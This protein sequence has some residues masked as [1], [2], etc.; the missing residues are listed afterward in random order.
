MEAIPLF[1]PYTMSDAQILKV[2]TAHETDFKKILSVIQNNQNKYA[3]KHIVICGPTGI[4]KSFLLRRLQIHFKPYKTIVFFLFPEIPSHLYCADDFLNDIQQFLLSKNDRMDI[5]QPTNNS[6]EENIH[7]LEHLIKMSAYKHVI[8]GIENLHMMI[9]DQGIFSSPVQQAKFQDLLQ[10]KSW[11]TL[12]TTYTDKY[13]HELD[14]F[15]EPFYRYELSEWSDQDHDQYLQKICAMHKSAGAGPNKIKQNVLRSFSG[16]LPRNSVILADILRHNNILSTI[17]ALETTI[18]WLTPYFQNQFFSL[19]PECRLLINALICSKEPCTLSELAKCVHSNE[20]DISKNIC[21]LSDHGFLNVISQDNHDAYSVKDRLFVHYYRVRHGSPLQCKRG[22]LSVVSEFL[23][24]FYD[25]Q[26]LKNMAKESFTQGHV[27]I[28]RDILHIILSHAG[29]SI[30][31]LPWKNDL[32]LLFQAFDLCFSKEFQ[33]P[34]SEKKAAIIHQQM[35]NLLKACQFY[36]NELNIKRFAYQITSHLFINEK[37][38][39]FLFQQ[40][41][42]NQLSFNQW[43]DLDLFFISQQTKLRNAY[44]EFLFPLIEMIQHDEIIPEIILESRIN[45]LKQNDPDIYRVLIAFCSD[46]LPLEISSTDHLDAHRRCLTMTQHI[47]FKVFHL[48][49]IGWHLGC[50]KAYN[51]AIDNF[52]SALAI[53]KRQ[54]NSVKQAWLFGQIGWCY[55]LLQHYDIAL[56]YHEKARQI[57]HDANDFINYAWNT[58]CIGRIFAKSCQYEAALIKHQEAIDVLEKNPDIKQI[59]WNWSRIARNQTNLKRYDMAMHAHQTA[60]ELLENDSDNDLKAWN[61]EGLAW[62]FGK[63]NQHD[64]AIKAQQQALKYRSLDGNIS[65]QAWNLEGIGWSLGKLERFEEAL[66]V[67]NRALKVREK[68]NHPKGQAWNLE[69]IA[70]FL[71]RLGRFDEAIAAHERALRFQEKENNFERQIWNYRGIAWNHKERNDYEQSIHAL[72]QAIQCAK[73]SENIYWQAA[74][75]ALIGWDLRKMHRMADA[76]KAHERA[77]SFY[78][79]LNNRIG[80]QENAGQMAINYFILGQTGRAWNILDH[81]GTLILSPDKMVAR[82]G[83]VVIYLIRNVRQ[84]MAYHTAINIIDGL[85]LRQN[86]WEISPILQALLLSLIMA[87][88]C[89]KFIYRIARYIKK[90]YQNHADCELQAIFDLIEFMY[91]N[92]HQEFLEQLDTNRRQ[93][94]ES[95]IDCIRT[96]WAFHS[97]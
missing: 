18:D 1:N 55:Q 54:N 65:Q 39:R 50:L 59:A 74:I 72:K 67:L 28:A 4:G 66:K 71:G 3:S 22:N 53:R 12:I 20:I 70:R 90:N 64:D 16:G 45:R 51:E 56:T 96:K 80:I 30:D 15:F 58:G 33:L 73:N 84:G 85:L 10:K 75:W 14:P 21:W 83:E 34:K 6:W 19:L 25:H 23:T 92:W 60:L 97:L 35:R 44:G 27:D 95:L 7:I 17:N 38:R 13:S 79:I 40:C 46:R 41:I 31:L 62:I 89:I 93:A 78:Q 37:M 26:D 49:Q 47:E 43:M 2:Q 52:Q 61:L 9:S 63:V 32:P 82:I 24:T 69:G 86:Q 94:V 68:S 5:S 76:I 36:P 88:L 81:Y 87:D 57:Y 11:L 42:S 91:R 77:I 48:E 8:L 29:F